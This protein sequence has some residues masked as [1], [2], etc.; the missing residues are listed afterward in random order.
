MAITNIQKVIDSADSMI[1]ASAEQKL[2]VAGVA[3]ACRKAAGLE[4]RRA[5]NQDSGK[6]LYVRANIFKRGIDVQRK[7]DRLHYSSILVDAEFVAAYDV[8]AHRPGR[9]ERNFK[10]AA[11]G[12]VI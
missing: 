11:A 4:Q 2:S 6:Q 3:A 10:P 1:K 9:F 8:G 7:P 5:S 12:D